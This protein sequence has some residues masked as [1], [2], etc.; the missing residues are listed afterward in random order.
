MLAKRPDLDDGF[1]PDVPD[2][3]EL[4]S[5]EE[6]DRD[7]HVDTILKFLYRAAAAG[8]DS[9]HA[10]SEAFYILDQHWLDRTPITAEQHDWL[11][12][13]AISVG[14]SILQLTSDQKIVEAAGAMTQALVDQIAIWAEAPERRAARPSDA[15]ADIRAGSADLP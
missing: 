10:L 12:G 1:D 13:A 11:R 8:E 5:R 2:V 4:A 14:R 9:A 7:L 15:L 3:P 6:Q